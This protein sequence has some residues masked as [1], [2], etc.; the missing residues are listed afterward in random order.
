MM[1]IVLSSLNG[2]KI[3]IFEVSWIVGLSH[4]QAKSKLHC[5][6]NRIQ[7]APICSVSLFAML[8]VFGLTKNYIIYITFLCNRILEL[9]QFLI[10][11][12]VI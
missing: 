10:L 8:T 1:S 7:R 9:L 3:C 5:L 2:L 6:R 4:L 12:L 11:L